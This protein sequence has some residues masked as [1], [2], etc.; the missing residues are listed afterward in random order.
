MSIKHGN[1]RYFQLLLD[2]YKA[3]ILEKEAKRR[4]QRPTALMRDLLF[5]AAEDIDPEGFPAANHSDRLLWEESVKNR[6]KGRT[7]ARMNRIVENL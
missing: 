5:K 1:K 3:A 6:I 2:P 4:G 7:E